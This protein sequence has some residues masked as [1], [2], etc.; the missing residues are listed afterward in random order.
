MIKFAGALAFNL[1]YTHWLDE[2]QRLINDLR[3]AINSHM[4]DNELRIL[5][6]SVML[7]YDEKFRIKSAGTKANVFHMLSGMW[8][9]PVER[10]LMW[11]GGFR[12]SE[13]LKV[14]FDILSSFLLPSVN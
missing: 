2:H 9:T 6:D 1:E 13:V 7:L 4:S 3:S 14:I 11:L 8:K 5:V 10:W 12:S